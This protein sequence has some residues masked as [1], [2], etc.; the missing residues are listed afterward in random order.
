MIIGCKRHQSRK[1]NSDAFGPRLNMLK[2]YSAHHRLKTKPP[3]IVRKR[4]LITPDIYS[5]CVPP[6]K[7]KVARTPVNIVMGEIQL[8]PTS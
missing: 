8:K 6:P 7:I 5:K 4:L 3:S 2:C 1:L